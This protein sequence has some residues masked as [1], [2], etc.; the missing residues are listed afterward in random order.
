MNSRQGVH[1]ALNGNASERPAAQRDVE[2]STLDIERSGVVDREADQIA[3]LFGQRGGRR[4]DPLGI[5]IER[6]DVRRPL[7]RECCQPSLAA[8][9]VEHT[10]AVEVDE[11]ADRS[12]LNAGSIT[13]LH[14]VERYAAACASRRG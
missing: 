8:A 2:P 14:G 4:C 1:D 6:I 9:D 10:L 5:R 11:P 12:G 3:Q 7:G 13:P